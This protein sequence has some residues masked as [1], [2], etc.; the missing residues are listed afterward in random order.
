MLYY[1][2][3]KIEERLVM[4][5]IL[6]EDVDNLGNI[7]DI[8]N[9]ANGYARN[10]LIPRN[11]GVE[12]NPRNIKQFEHVKR[13]VGIKAEKLR[14]EKMDIAD[15]LKAVK[16]TVKAKAGEEGKLFGSVTSM[17]VQQEL[18]GQGFE[19]DKKKIV[20]EPPIKRLGEYD[21][22]VKLH[23]DVVADIKVEVIPAE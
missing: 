17:D 13:I 2:K 23:S 4:K 9:V 15:K 6:K 5:V 20:I 16:L 14:K 18:A 7:G 11:L 21:V 22:K 10:F 1:H 19:I 3:L 12:A 8:V